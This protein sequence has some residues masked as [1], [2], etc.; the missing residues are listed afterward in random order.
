LTTGTILRAATQQDLEEVLAWLKEEDRNEGTGF[1]C[2]RNVI[3]DA[4]MDGELQVAVLDG[5][6][7]A[8]LAYGLTRNGI[9]E[10]EPRFRGRGL[11]RQLVERAI[12]A[13]QD[14]DERCILE[15]QC[16][17]ET[18]V[19]FWKHLGFAIFEQH[20]QTYGRM[21][22]ER[23]LRVP[24]GEVVS[25]LVEHHWD[26]AQHY[27]PATPVCLAEPP[28]VRLQSGEIVLGQR[29]ILADDTPQF[30]GDRRDPV[31]RIMVEGRQI[32][33]DKVKRER[34]R[35]LGMEQDCNGVFYLDRLLDV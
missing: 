4:F 23:A 17:P 7:M 2:N 11:A 32:F 12:R 5:H 28:A 10:T 22:L 25:V 18:S 20:G 14:R 8:L 35:V 24:N 21:I 29:V 27:P 31:A 3:Q 16:A 33:F 30:S 13:E 1:W 6:P 26:P 19:P 15:F 9:L 34:A